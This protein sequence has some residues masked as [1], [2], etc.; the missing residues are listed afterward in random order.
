MG[1][2]KELTAV[3]LAGGFGSRLK[4]VINNCPKPMALVNGKPFLEHLLTSITKSNKISKIVLSV[5]YRYE[6]ICSYFKDYFKDIPI[7]YSIE[8]KP[9]GTGGAVLKSIQNIAEQQFVLINGDTLFTVDISK[10]IFEHINKQADVTIALKAMKNID[11]YGTVVCENNKIIKFKEKMFIE[12]GFINGGIY[13]INKSIFLSG[14][15]P[16]VFS[17]E[18]DF[19]EQNVNDYNFIGVPF[20]SYF[21]DIGI[22]EDL[23]K[24]QTELFLN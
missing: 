10:L 22:P 23:A 6:E 20:D 16:E 3:L 14:L 13:I 15:F 5:G 17:F 8:D 24:A 7:E 12:E 18:K 4:S 11:R 2:N 9:L 21:I 1:T 19:L